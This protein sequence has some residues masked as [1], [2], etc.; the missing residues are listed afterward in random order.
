[1][2]EYLRLLAERRFDEAADDAVN[3]DW[4]PADVIPELAAAIDDGRI[5]DSVSFAAQLEQSMQRE[6]R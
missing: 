6:R 3:A 5:G 2:R 4:I 1:M